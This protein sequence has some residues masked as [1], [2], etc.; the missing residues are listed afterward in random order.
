MAGKGFSGVIFR[1]LGGGCH[2]ET[3]FQAQSM[4]SSIRW[5]W[6]N[7]DLWVFRRD[8]GPSRSDDAKIGI[9]R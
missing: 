6:W 8:E 9:S 2:K 5:G 1:P 4:Y 7:G 3:T